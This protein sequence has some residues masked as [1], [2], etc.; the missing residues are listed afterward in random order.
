VSVVEPGCVRATAYIKRDAF[1][2]YVLVDSPITFK[3]PI[4]VLCVR[5]TLCF[6]TDIYSGMSKSIC[7][8]Q[9]AG[10][11][12]DTIGTV[13]NNEVQRHRHTICAARDVRRCDN[14]VRYSNTKCYRR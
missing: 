1:E 5:L 4:S 11:I 3:V 7:V 13:G 2:E 9:Y 10:D 14:G 8:V 12:R 6:A